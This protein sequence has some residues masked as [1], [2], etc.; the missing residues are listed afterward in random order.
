MEWL[1]KILKEM[2]VKEG[3]VDVAAVME[4]VK[5]AFPLHAVPKEVFNDK[6]KE[7]KTANDTIA[8]LK[9]SNGENEELQKKIVAYET[10]VQSLKKAADDTVKS[11]ALKEKLVKAGVKDL[12][13]LIYKHGG[14]EKFTFNKEHQPIG[15]DD[16]LKTYKEDAAMT[17]LFET[18][19]ENGY[20]P[21]G[22]KSP[23]VNPFAKETYNMTE[24]ANLFRSNP[25]QAKALAA[26]AGVV[27]S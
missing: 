5:T 26:A 11:Y 20:Q 18:K 12:D 15:V 13:Y 19:Q 24:Q 10:E 8:D 14:L 23:A 22:G 3:K 1:E 27:I 4:K 7:L 16:V 25:E 17:H 9:K 2:E 6:V 21:T